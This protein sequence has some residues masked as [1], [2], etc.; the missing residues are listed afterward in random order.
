[1][2]FLDVTRS[3]Q[4]DLAPWP[5]DAVF[6]YRLVARLAEGSSV[7]LGRIATSLH[8]GTHADAFFHFDD[9]GLTIDQFPPERY[10]GT[11]DGHRPDREVRERN[12]RRDHDRRPRGRRDRPEA[13][14]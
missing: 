13:P 7:N 2:K 10:V 1:M 5:G 12:H 9:S 14:G 3:L 4:S 8:S 11:A 6:D